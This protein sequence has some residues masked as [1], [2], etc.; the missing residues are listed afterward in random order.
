MRGV[1]VKGCTGRTAIEAYQ[2]GAVKLDGCTLSNNERCKHGD[3]Y[4][5][6]GRNLGTIVVDGK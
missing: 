4:P 2:K 5:W 6:H 1:V 3:Y